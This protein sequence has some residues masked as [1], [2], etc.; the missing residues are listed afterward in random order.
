MANIPIYPGSSSFTPGDTPFGFYDTD[1]TFQTDVDKFATFAARRLGYPIVD[2]E[3]QDLN[4]YAAFEEAV[5]IYGNEVYAYKVR[6]DYLS[7]EG[8]N[9]SSSVPI[10]AGQ[11]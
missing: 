1:A 7:L 4:F 2:V 10:V 3:L 6:Q 9:I 5:T 11:N 8:T